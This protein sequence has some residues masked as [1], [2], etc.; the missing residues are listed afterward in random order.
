MTTRYLDQKFKKIYVNSLFRSKIMF[1]LETWGG[2]PRTSISKVNRLQIQAAKLAAGGTHPR[3]SDH[4]MQKR[5]GW[6]TLDQQIAM[7]HPHTNMEN[8]EPREYQRR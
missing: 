1:A 5:L 4:A 3:D 2:A 7:V 8:I 6:P